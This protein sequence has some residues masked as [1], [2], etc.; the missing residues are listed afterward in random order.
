MKTNTSHARPKHGAIYAHPFPNVT[1][2]NAL[3]TGSGAASLKRTRFSPAISARSSE[4]A[5][6]TGLE[7]R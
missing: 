6:R 3:S 5:A 7:L 4:Q 1:S 2:P